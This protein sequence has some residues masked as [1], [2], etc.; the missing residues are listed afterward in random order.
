MPSERAHFKIRFLRRLR[1]ERR[2]ATYVIGGRVYF[3]LT[4]LDTFIEA[5]RTEAVAR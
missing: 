4:E 1:A 5:Q 3:D 2:V